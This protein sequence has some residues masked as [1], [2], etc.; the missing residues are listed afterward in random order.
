MVLGSR[1]HGGYEGVWFPSTGTAGE[2]GGAGRAGAPLLP[3]VSE[4]SA[5]RRPGTAP[6]P[7]PCR[8]VP[9]PSP[10]GLAAGAPGVA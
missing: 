3:A 8:H 10:T 6:R 1:D 5:R 7:R 4:L 9:M 2:V